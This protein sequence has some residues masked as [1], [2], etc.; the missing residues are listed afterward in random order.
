MLWKSRVS[1]N[2]H[3]VLKQFYFMVLKYNEFV[4]IPFVK[5][6]G[7]VIGLQIRINVHKP[8]KFLANH[9]YE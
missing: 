5:I 3:E 7:N 2:E 6:L 9:I 1:S 4:H 8:V